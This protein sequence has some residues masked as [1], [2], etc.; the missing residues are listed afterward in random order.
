MAGYYFH[1]HM[2]SPEGVGGACREC[3]GRALLLILLCREKQRISKEN[4]GLLIK[5]R[6][7]DGVRLSSGMKCARRSDNHEGLAVK[8]S[9][10]RVS[11]CFIKAEMIDAVMR[12]MCGVRNKS[13]E[14]VC[15]LEGM[16]Q[17]D[18]MA[19][20]FSLNLALYVQGSTEHALPNMFG[21]SLCDVSD[22][23]LWQAILYNQSSDSFGKDVCDII[24]PK[25]SRV[26]GSKGKKT[27]EESQETINVSEES[28]P[29]LAKKKTYGKRRVKKKVTMPADDNIISDDPDAALELAKSIS[30]TEAEEAEAA[31][32]VHA[33]HARIVTKF[34]AVNIMQALKESKKTSRRQPGTGGSNEGTGSKPRVPDESTVVSAT[35]S[36][37]TGAKPGVP[38]E[39]KD[40]TKEKVILEWGDE[41]YSEFFDNDKEGS[42]NINCQTAQQSY[43]ILPGNGAKNLIESLYYI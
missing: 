17:Y 21:V 33:I 10:K 15:R 14:G 35:S 16:F 5:M 26:K 30:Q 28:K 12:S 8:Y 4:F 18:D 7:L 31:K 29:E 42:S 23:E 11:Y 13:S 40:I 25:K 20:T 32:K 38:D 34:E 41:Q 9:L 1:E 6:G 37:R 24:L 2:A 43:T 19:L 22:G 27:V 3:K 39:D 36:E